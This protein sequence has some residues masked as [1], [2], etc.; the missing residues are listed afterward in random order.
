MLTYNIS[1]SFLFDDNIKRLFDDE[2]LLLK[3]FVKL[4]FVFPCR[5][6]CI[7]S[8]LICLYFIF[9][10]PYILY[11]FIGFGV[12]YGK[13]GCLVASFVSVVLAPI[14]QKKLNLE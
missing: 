8:K 12:N 3:L 14:V 1:F 6:W 10:L 5:L 7:L 4:V 2:F 9:T 13:Y 11:Y